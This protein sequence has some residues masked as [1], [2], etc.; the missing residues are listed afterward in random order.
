MD[1]EKSSAVEQ[2]R[3]GPDSAPAHIAPFET[4]QSV[5]DKH[6]LT[7]EELSS[8]DL[9]ELTSFSHKKDDIDQKIQIAS[10]WPELDPFQDVSTHILDQEALGASRAHLDTLSRELNHARLQR[11][12]LEAA[13]QQFDLQDMTRL[14]TVAKGESMQRS[15]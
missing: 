11:E 8:R 10:A 12:Q 14:R 6:K 7:R 15:A 13:V 5:G 1:L 9:V 3:A 4:L 2:P